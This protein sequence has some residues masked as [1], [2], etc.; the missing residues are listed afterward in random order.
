MA[1]EAGD[2][3]LSLGGVIPDLEG[4]FGCLFFALPGLQNGA[5]DGIALL[6]DKGAMLQFISYEGLVKGA[7]GAGRGYL[8]MEIGVERSGSDP[9]GSS[10]QLHGTGSVPDDFRWEGPLPASPGEVE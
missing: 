1:A 9:A 3:S 8:S 7:D 5:P 10:L 4:G 6:N 2:G